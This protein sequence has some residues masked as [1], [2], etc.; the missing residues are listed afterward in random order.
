MRRP[1]L[2]VLLALLFAPVSFAATPA[3]QPNPPDLGT[4]VRRV[5]ADK[6]VECHSPGLSH[7]KGKFGYVLDLSRV[8]A[9][10]KIVV[11][12]DPAAS[13][14][15]KQI[16]DGDMPPDDAEAG[17]LTDPQ[18]R[19]IHLWVEA[20]APAPLTAQIDPVV[21]SEPLVVAPQSMLTRTLRMIGKLHVLIIHFPI[22]LLAAAAIAESWRIW[23]GRKG[24]SPVVRFCVLTGAA[25][26]I[27]AAAVG[28]IH[29]S[30]GGFGADS[31]Q[32]L[33]LHRWLGTAAGIGAVVTAAACEWDVLRERRTVL[34]RGI[35]FASAAMVG[36]AGHFGGMLVYGA[37]FFRL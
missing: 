9:N 6:C 4:Q 29:A 13:K 20:G 15:W 14:L 12:F 18:K 25:A 26:A 34:F 5:F 10:P 32:A 7:P 1:H 28:W 11:R 16:E 37:D 31:S 23:T 35:L 33:M 30:Y 3:A 17:P 19:L 8:A 27:V 22:A 24:Q 2:A 36:A 21:A